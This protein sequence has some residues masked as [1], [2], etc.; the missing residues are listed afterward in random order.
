MNCVK[1]HKGLVKDY[2]KNKSLRAISDHPNTPL[3]SIET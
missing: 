1:T 3:S 2:N